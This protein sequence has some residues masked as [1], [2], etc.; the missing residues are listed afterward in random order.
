M[1]RF[2]M[3][4][5][6]AVMAATPVSAATHQLTAHLS[7]SYA[8]DRTY[9]NEPFAGAQAGDT[10]ELTMTY[11]QPVV[12]NTQPWGAP[13]LKGMLAG[14]FVRTGATLSDPGPATYQLLGATGDLISSG[15]AIRLGGSYDYLLAL[16]VFE[17]G[18]TTGGTFTGFRLTYTVETGF[19][20]D[21]TVATFAAGVPEPASWALMIAGFGMAG[22]AARRRLS[23]IRSFG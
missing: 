11:G 2:S 18:V 21:E 3:A 9:P 12:V 23:H 17:E 5:M 10:I 8:V 4:A 6:G 14:L 13:G 16:P 7:Y 20:A 15:D 1:L 22:A 19:S